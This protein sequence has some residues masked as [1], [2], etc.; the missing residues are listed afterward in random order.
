MRPSLE[1]PAVTYV[2]E[3]AFLVDGAN[4]SDRRPSR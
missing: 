3:S 4:V 2:A 1:A